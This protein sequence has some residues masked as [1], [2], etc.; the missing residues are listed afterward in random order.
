MRSLRVLAGTGLFSERSAYRAPACNMSVG[1]TSVRPDSGRGKADILMTARMYS[2]LGRRSRLFYPQ[3]R[4]IRTTPPL[5]PQHYERP[6]DISNALS[7]MRHG[8]S[9]ADSFCVAFFQFPMGKEILKA[10]EEVVERNATD[11]LADSSMNA[12]LALLKYANL[13]ELQVLTDHEKTCSFQG[14][15]EQALAKLSSAMLSWSPSRSEEVFAE[16]QS[17][18]SKALHAGVHAVALATSTAVMSTSV[19]MSE[20]DSQMSNFEG[21]GGKGIAILAN[22]SSEA[23]R[24]WSAIEDLLSVGRNNLNKLL[25]FLGKAPSMLKVRKNVVT[26]FCTLVHDDISAALAW[27][28]SLSEI[29]SGVASIGALASNTPA[30]PPTAL[31]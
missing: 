2:I 28:E 26:S 12:G 16:V 11:I 23:M 18:V 27:A 7:I 29:L 6:S 25:I 30:P 3:T 22:L 10:A 8:D 9:K 4:S 13:A 14:T 31:R 19:L 21:S 15:V 20:A 1:Y 17:F 5:P 24:S